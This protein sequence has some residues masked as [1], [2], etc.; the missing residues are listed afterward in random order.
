ML[1]SIKTAIARSRE[2]AAA[3]RAYRYLEGQ[4][5]HM[6]KDMGLSRDGLYG[7]VVGRNRH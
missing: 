5:D 6:L 7:A 2:R 4:S 3:K 1:S